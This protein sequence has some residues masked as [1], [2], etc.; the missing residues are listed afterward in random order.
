MTTHTIPLPDSRLLTRRLIT[1]RDCWEWQGSRRN[2]YGRIS[3]GGR[4]LSVHRYAAS[5]W[6][7]GFEYDDMSLQVCH[8]CDNP[9]CYNPSHLFIGSASDNMQD[10]ARKGR[11]VSQA[12]RQRET[13]HPRRRECVVCGIGFEP[14]P[15]HRGR[16]K[17][18]GARSCTSARKGAQR[19][20]KAIKITDAQVAEC[21]ALI[22]GGLTYKQAAAR[23]GMTAGGL[24]RRLNPNGAGR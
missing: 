8:A 2:G 20:G 16:A 14:H 11:L 7:H 9:P 10:A 19:R 4:L 13:V 18:C 23:Y 24:H 21:A 17:T 3:V 15:D 6:I 5:I 22:A 1:E 12:G